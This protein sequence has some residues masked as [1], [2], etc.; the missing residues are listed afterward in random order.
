LVVRFLTKDESAAWADALGHDGSTAARDLPHI[1]VRLPSQPSYY[2]FCRAI[3]E[4]IEPRSSCLLWIVQHGIWPSSENWH[5]YYRLRQSYGEHRLLHEAPGHLFLDYESPDLVSF[6][7]IA[8]ACGWDANMFPQL[9]YG[10]AGSARV[11]ISHDEFIVLAHRDETIVE[12]W[13]TLFE[14]WLKV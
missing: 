13:Q 9:S 12:K 8:L 11:L 6:L 2:A 3:A 14:S 1:E 7:Q 5:L 10:D 4:A